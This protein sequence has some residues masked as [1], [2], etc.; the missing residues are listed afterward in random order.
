MEIVGRS[1]TGEVGALVGY[2]MS[3]NYR[4]SGDCE[5]L[6]DDGFRDRRG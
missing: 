6:L 5:G 4:L 1:D 2:G 3:E